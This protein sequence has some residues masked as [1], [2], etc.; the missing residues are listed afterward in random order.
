MKYSLY[1]WLILVSPV[2]AET[3]GNFEQLPQPEET[4]IDP[5]FA[6]MSMWYK[7]MQVNF[8]LHIPYSV[9]D[10]QDEQYPLVI[11]FA[12]MGGAGEDNT[13]QLRGLD[14]LIPKLETKKFFLLATQVPS[15]RAYWVS[16]SAYKHRPLSPQD[17]VNVEDSSV[18]ITRQIVDEIIYTFPIDTKRIYVIGVSDGCNAV[19]EFIKFNDLSIAV[20]V[21][22]SG[23]PSLGTPVTDAWVAMIYGEEDTLLDASRINKYAESIKMSTGRSYLY[24]C[25][26]NTVGSKHDSHKAAF[27]HLNIMDWVLQHSRN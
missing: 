17:Q 21:F 3:I 18:Y 5:Y 13:K 10:K 24:R 20:A 12:G 9:Q 2:F 22:I 11:W 15:K 6:A 23:Q 25:E 7:N 4:V 16:S 19:S 14:L 8:R 26:K 27:G 1:L